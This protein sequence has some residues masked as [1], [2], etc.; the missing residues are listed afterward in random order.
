MGLSTTAAPTYRP[1]MRCCKGSGSVGASGPRMIHRVLMYLMRIWGL[2][3]IRMPE[4]LRICSRI[5]SVIT[6]ITS[7]VRP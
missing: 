3:S 7:D 6:L 4:E 2:V 5:A 1:R